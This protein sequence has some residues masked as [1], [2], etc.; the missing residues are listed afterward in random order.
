[1]GAVEVLSLTGYPC[2]QAHP[3]ANCSEGGDEL[4]GL[5]RCGHVAM[6]QRGAGCRAPLPEPSPRLVGFLLVEGPT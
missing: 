6:P 1:M 4:C 5:A 2:P 3:S